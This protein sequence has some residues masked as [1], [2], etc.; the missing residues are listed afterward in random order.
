[1]LHTLATRRQFLGGRQIICHLVPSM[2]NVDADVCVRPF[3]VDA[4]TVRAVAG[5][6]SSPPAWLPETLR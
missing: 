1:M 4:T 6:A 3:G 5:T 2:L